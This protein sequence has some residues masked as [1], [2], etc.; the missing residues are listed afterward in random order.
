MSGVLHREADVGEDW[1]RAGPPLVED[2]D[3]GFR[4]A[5]LYPR[6]TGLPMTVW[7]GPRAGARHD[8][9]VKVCMA[10][11]NVMHVDRLATVAVRPRPTLLHG[12]LSKT[13]FDYVARWIRLNEQAI[14]AHWDGE[15]DGAEFIEAL[16]AI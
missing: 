13:D 2:E 4:M 10:H 15:T 9:R 6:T 11:G 12:E 5:N 1:L 14:L 3:F 16:K 7:V 8:V